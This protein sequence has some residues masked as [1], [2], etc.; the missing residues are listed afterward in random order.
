MEKQHHITLVLEKSNI[1]LALGDIST[2]EKS[3]NVA[4][5]L[6]EQFDDPLSK[7]NARGHIATIKKTQG[8]LDEALRIREKEQLPVYEKL[9]D[10]RSLLVAQANM[11]R[12]LITRAQADDN[13]QA[14]QLLS[15][16]LTAAIEMQLPETHQI[17]AIMA[18][19][20]WLPEDI[21]EQLAI[22]K[23]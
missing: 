21:H 22:H 4:T 12:L 17:I 20:N 18:E 5:E 14:R 19:N 9:G 10:K 2:A 6:A 16:A 23:P 7:A 11:A 3:A 8:K 1:H 15:Q 13:N